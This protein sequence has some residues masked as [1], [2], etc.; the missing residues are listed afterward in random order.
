MTGED[1]KISV[2]NKYSIL[3]QFH[4]EIDEK[5]VDLLLYYKKIIL[6]SNLESILQVI[7][8]YDSLLIIYAST[9]DKIYRQKEHLRSLIIDCQNIPE[10]QSRTLEIP[11]CYDQEFGLDLKLISEENNLEIPE[12]PKLHTADKYRVFFIGFLPGFPYLSH[13]DSR[14]KINR[15]KEPR[16]SIE[17]GSVGIA[18]LQTGIYPESSPAG[19]QIIG[20]TPVQLFD[21]VKH[22]SVL[23]AGDYLKFKAIDKK[24]FEEIQDR[25]FHDAYTI[26]IK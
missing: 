5:N 14:L 25:V 26:K 6:E 16:A 10:I 4:F 20:R 24:Q 22:Q 15:K 9:I 11:V 18:G 19:W 13:V 3:I 21:E 17:K 23:K 7:N 12:I 2:Y 8:T 1:F